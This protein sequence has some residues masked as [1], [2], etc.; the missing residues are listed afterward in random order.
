[1]AKLKN[2][3]IDAIYNKLYPQIISIRENKLKE[4]KE[5][6]KLDKK[7]KEFLYIIQELKELKIKCEQLESLG[8]SLAKEIFNINPKDYYYGWK[9]TT[10]EDLINLYAEQLLP[11][12]LQNIASDL[13][14]RIIIAN[15]DGNTQDLIDTILTEY[16]D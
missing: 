15:I 5:T 4:L 8:S 2:Y 16:N 6:V 9:G 14:D 10:E 3:E 13:R 12:N 1:M 11:N 7:A